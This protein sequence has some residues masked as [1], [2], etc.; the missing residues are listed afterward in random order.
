MTKQREIETHESGAVSLTGEGIDLARLIALAQG[1]S[2]AIKIPGMKLSARLP[3]SS[4]IARRMGFRG[5]KETQLRAVLAEIE[6]L[7]NKVGAS[8]HDILAIHDSMTR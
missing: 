7:K 8:S 1:L 4:T 6:R 3:A 2:L 5:N